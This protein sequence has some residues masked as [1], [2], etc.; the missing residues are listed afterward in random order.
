MRF[1]QEDVYHSSQREGGLGVAHRSGA[2]EDEDAVGAGLFAGGDAK[3]LW[4]ADDL[5]REERG[6]HPAVLAKPDGA[7]GGLLG[8]GEVW[9]VAVAAQTQA[10]FKAAEQ[11]GEEAE[12]DGAAEEELEWPDKRSGGRHRGVRRSG[13]GGA[14]RLRRLATACTTLR[15]ACR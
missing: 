15:K 14:E 5:R 7:V 11:Q 8:A 12:R 9:R 1:A 3:R 2:A 6:S 4:A 10:E 13:C